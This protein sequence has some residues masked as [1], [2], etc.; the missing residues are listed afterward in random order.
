[1]III[2]I[3][4]IKQKINWQNKQQIKTR[5]FSAHRKHV[6]KSSS[7]VSGMCFATN[8]DP[9]KHVLHDGFSF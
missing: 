9:A 7:Q 8:R 5:V 2:I 4:K 1:M 3:C 6:H